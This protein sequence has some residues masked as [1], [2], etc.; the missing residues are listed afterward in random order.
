MDPVAEGAA[1]SIVGPPTYTVH[2][3]Y[4]LFARRGEVGWVALKSLPCALFL[5]EKFEETRVSASGYVG[6][7][8]VD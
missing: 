6:L 7:P 3:E 4:G 2:T 5:H 1:G 8:D